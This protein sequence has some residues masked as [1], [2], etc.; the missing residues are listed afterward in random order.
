MRRKYASGYSCPVESRPRTRV[1]F[2]RLPNISRQQSNH[3]LDTATQFP[4]CTRRITKKRAKS[5]LGIAARQ[6]RRY[7]AHKIELFYKK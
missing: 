2:G 1:Q 7:L 3:N 4:G 6:N 5:I